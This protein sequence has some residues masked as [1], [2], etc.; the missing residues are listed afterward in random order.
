MIVP[1]H[2]KITIGKSKITHWGG[3]GAAGYVG[4]ISC[5]TVKDSGRFK[6]SDAPGDV[7]CK[8][9]LPLS[10]IFSGDMIEMEEPTM[11]GSGSAL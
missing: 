11:V 5:G 4:Y 3:V 10:S 6:I 9:C 2:V 1:S 7:T 8:F